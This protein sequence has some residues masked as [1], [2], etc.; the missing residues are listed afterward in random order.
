VRDV[1]VQ[2]AARESAAS[3]KYTR[4]VAAERILPRLDVT[5]KKS[6]I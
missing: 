1:F 2:V 4:P 6:A 5:K 3:L